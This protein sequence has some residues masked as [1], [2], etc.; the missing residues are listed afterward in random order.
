MLY[1]MSERTHERAD[2]AV[3]RAARPFCL[4]DPVEMI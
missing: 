3:K 1:R 2:H 4:H